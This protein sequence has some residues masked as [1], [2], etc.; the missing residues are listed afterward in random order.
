MRLSA[1]EAVAQLLQSMD[2]AETLPPTPDLLQ[3]FEQLRGPALATVLEW[4]GQAAERE[5]ASAARG[6]RCAARVAEYRG[7]GES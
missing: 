7:A 1:P 6:C 5:G 2:E 3:L 4:L